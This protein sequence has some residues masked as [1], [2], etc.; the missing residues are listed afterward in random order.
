MNLKHLLSLSLLA[1]TACGG[2]SERS[3]T[4]A[5]GQALTRGNPLPIQEQDP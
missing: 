3:A 1:L 4:A 5:R 2:G